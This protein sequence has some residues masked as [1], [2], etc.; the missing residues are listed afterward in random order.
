MPIQSLLNLNPDQLTHAQIVARLDFLCA[1]NWPPNLLAEWYGIELEGEDQRLLAH[2]RIWLESFQRGGSR[3]SISSIPRHAFDL[4]LQRRELIC[5]RAIALEFGM[6]PESF[7]SLLDAS[8]EKDII[9][10]REKMGEFPGVYRRS[11]LRDYHKRFS[12]L[13]RLP[14]PGHSKFLIR[15]HEQIEK[16]LGFIPEQV[17]CSTFP[18]VRERGCDGSAEPVFAHFFDVLTGEPVNASFEIWLNTTRPVQLRPDSC[19]WKTFMR[20]EQILKNKVVGELDEML[21]KAGPSIKGYFN[22]GS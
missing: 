17:L 1:D 20:F 2:F 6:T 11:F 12:E 14:F 9:N 13:Q 16:H 8:L 22:L 3:Y 15:L 5:R 21:E 19:S 10:P 4:F 18:V 7:D